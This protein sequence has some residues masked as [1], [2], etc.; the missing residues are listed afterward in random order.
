MLSSTWAVVWRRAPGA[1]PDSGSA[2]D[3]KSDF[4]SIGFGSSEK[5]SIPQGV[6]MQ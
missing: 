3:F 1:F 2:L 6:S 4:N 5:G